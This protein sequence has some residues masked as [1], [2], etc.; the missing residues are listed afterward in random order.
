[1]HLT[2]YQMYNRIF[3]VLDLPL[4]GDIL[5][6][7]GIKYWQGSKNYTPLRKIIDDDARITNADYPKVHICDLPHENNHFDYVIC[8]QVLEHVEGDIEKA[9]SEI[10]RVLKPGGTAVIATVFINPVHYGPKDLWRFSLDALRYLCRDFSEI[11]QCEG[12]GNRFAHALFFL[13]PRS[14]DWQV[15]NHWWSITRALVSRND[16]N[17]PQ[18]TWTIAKK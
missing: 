1:M 13:Y 17:Y 16:L 8:D 4:S 3:S 18:Q 12:W 7:S 15:K 9:V 5:A 11:I 6:I 2:R 10:H 14:R